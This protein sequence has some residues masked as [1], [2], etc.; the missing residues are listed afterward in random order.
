MV[1]KAKR[2]ARR[3]ESKNRPTNPKKIKQAEELAELIKGY[4]I[5]GILNLYKMPSRALQAI[6]KELGDDALI[7]VSKKSVLINALEKLEDKKELIGKLEGQPGL[8]LTKMNPFKLYMFLQ[9]KKSPGPA[10]PGD[11]APKDIEVKAGPTDLMPGPAISTLSGA[12]IPAKVEGGKIAIIRDKIVV[13]AGEEVSQ[14]ISGIFQMLK[15]MPMEIGLDLPY[16]WEGGLIY[17][18]DVLAI[19]EEEMFS[20]FTQAVHNAYNLSINSG[21]PTKE[22]VSMMISKAFMEA[23]SLA[24]DA[25]ILD[26]GIIED[27]LAKAKIQGEALK[28][29]TG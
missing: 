15:I 23:K 27:L 13:K 2:L 18:K 7:R 10:K 19:D 5:V 26:K 24:L 11:I 8:L 25:A 4:P 20:R 1:G 28:A 14:Q 3:K 6:R 16:V 17:S 29:K 21:Y 22:T 12:G 9:K